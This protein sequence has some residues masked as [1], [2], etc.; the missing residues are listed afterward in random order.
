MSL[1]FFLLLV[2]VSVPI[3]VSVYGCVLAVCDVEVRRQPQV[4]LL[5]ESLLCGL[6][7]AGL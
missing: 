6:G 4:V 2:F 3:C 1:N 5:L 7:L